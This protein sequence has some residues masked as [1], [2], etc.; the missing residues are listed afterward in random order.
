MSQTP[1][2]NKANLLA[3]DCCHSDLYLSIL[4]NCQ[5]SKDFPVSSLIIVST[6]PMGWSIHWHRL[7]STMYTVS[8]TDMSSSSCMI[9]GIGSSS[10]GCCSRVSLG[11]C[12]FIAGTCNDFPHYTLQSFLRQLSCHSTPVVAIQWLAQISGSFHSSVGWDNGRDSDIVMI[13]FD[14]VT[15]IIVQ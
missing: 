5:Y 10:Q 2:A 7:G 11:G 8:K 12:W 1:F 13:K 14:N 3:N 15:M 4:I 9:F 6:Y